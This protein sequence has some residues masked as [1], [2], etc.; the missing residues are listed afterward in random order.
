MRKKIC[1]EESVFARIWDNADADGLW[2]GD[3]ESVAAKFNVTKDAAYDALTELCD[4]GRIQRVGSATYIVTK[5]PER[6]EPDE[7]ELSS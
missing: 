5:W 2:T 6:D 4:R 3:A 1:D 7:E